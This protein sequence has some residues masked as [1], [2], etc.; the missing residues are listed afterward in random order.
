MEIKNAE[1]IS[2][3][4]KLQELFFRNNGKD[5][6]ASQRR[7]VPNTSEQIDKHRNPSLTFKLR[8]SYLRKSWPACHRIGR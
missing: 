5:C 7:Q 6:E 2:P 8:S 4:K 1:K 3:F